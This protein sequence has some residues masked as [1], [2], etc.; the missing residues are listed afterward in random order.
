[1]IEVTEDLPAASALEKALTGAGLVS[2]LLLLAG[3]AAGAV[4]LARRREVLVLGLTALPIAYQ[5]IVGTGPEADSRFHVR[6]VP[7]LA[8][9]AA[10][11][12]AGRRCQ[13]DDAKN[14]RQVGPGP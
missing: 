14:E 8:I 4:V 12:V 6:I 7:L 1:M 13:R 11:A 3:G 5:L 9:L 10:T 2:A